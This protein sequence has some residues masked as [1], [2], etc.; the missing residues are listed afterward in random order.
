MSFIGPRALR[1]DEYKL[2]E[3]KSVKNRE[4]LKIMTSVLPGISGY[5][6]VSGRSEITFEQRMEMETYYA[7]Q[8]SL[9]LDF[10]IILKTPYAM[11]VGK[12]GE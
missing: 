10:V 8:K 2:Y 4:Q 1:P 9:F 3:E 5:W 12:T 7:H 6:Q 11:L